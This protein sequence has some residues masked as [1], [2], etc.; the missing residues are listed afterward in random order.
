MAE[1]EGLFLRD[2]STMGAQLGT[3]AVRIAVKDRL[4]NQRMLEICAA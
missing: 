4:T 1:R 2:A 3:H